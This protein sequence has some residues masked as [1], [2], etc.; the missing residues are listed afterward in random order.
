VPHIIDE[1]LARWLVAP[2]PSTEV[3]PSPPSVEGR[4]MEGRSVAVC[5]LGPPLVGASMMVVR[6]PIEAHV[7]LPSSQVPDTRSSSIQVAMT[8]CI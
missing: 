2:P 3:I 8:Q 7:L 4:V 1:L 5:A 6:E